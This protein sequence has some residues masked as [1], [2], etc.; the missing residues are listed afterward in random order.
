MKPNGDENSTSNNSATSD[1][2]SSRARNANDENGKETCFLEIKKRNCYEFDN[3]ASTTTPARTPLLDT[4]LEQAK[5]ALYAS[6]CSSTSSSSSYS[7]SDEIP[8]RYSSLSNHDRQVKVT[9]NSS[10]RGDESVCKCRKRGKIFNCSKCTRNYPIHVRRTFGDGE[11]NGSIFSVESDRLPSTFNL[12]NKAQAA[13]TSTSVSSSFNPNSR[14]YDGATHHDQLIQR[15]DESSSSSYSSSSSSSSSYRHLSKSVT[16]ASLKLKPSPIPVSS[17]LLSLLSLN[18][19]N[20]SFAPP[21][22][23]NIALFQN[24]KK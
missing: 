23:I 11:T 13:S 6:E 9:H 2:T 10:A 14:S 15:T 18:K 7:N 21:P 16:T 20:N 12:R 22:N 3:L 4:S 19:P 1:D 17:T 8:H 24:G 5:P